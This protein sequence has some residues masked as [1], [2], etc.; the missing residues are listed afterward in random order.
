MSWG[1]CCT[2]APQELLLGLP[3]EGEEILGAEVGDL[4]EKMDRCPARTAAR[5]PAKRGAGRAKRGAGASQKGVGP[6]KKYVLGKK[7]VFLLLW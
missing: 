6:A 5:P 2:D 4:G 7:N 1:G 3:Q